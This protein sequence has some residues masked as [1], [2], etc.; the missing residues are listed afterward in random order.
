MED[1]VS[2]ILG[3]GLFIV[4]VILEGIVIGFGG[5]I[6]NVSD[7]DLDA[8][9]G[10]NDKKHHLLQMY[11][12]NR[13]RYLQIIQCATVIL[14][15]CN[16]FVQY[17]SWNHFLH[18]QLGYSGFICNLLIFIVV[19]FLFLILGIF[20]PWIVCERKAK[21]KAFSY[22]WAF[23]CI[24]CIL[25]PVLGIV[26]LISR[27]ISRLFGVDPTT[28]LDDVTEEEIISMVNEGHEHGVLLASEAA[29]IQNIFE[30]GDKNAKD[31]MIHR[32]NIIAMDGTWSL[33]DAVSFMNENHN[34]RYPVYQ[35]NLDDIIGI[36]HIK[37]A[38]EYMEK[39][40]ML[41]KEIKDIPGLIRQAE[42]VP[43][44]HGIN[45]LFTKM[46]S[47]KNHMV[48]VV[49][50]YGQTSGIISMEDILEEIVGNIQ[51]EHDDEEDTIEK[52][53]EDHFI[54]EGRTS[55]DEVAEILDIS[56][57]DEEV[58]TLNGFLISKI[59][60]IPSDHESFVVTAKGYEF[61]V[62]DVEN[63]MI[64]N[65]RVKKMTSGDTLESI[66]EK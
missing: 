55:L 5:G 36:F 1:G 33:K 66:Q 31:I 34:S 32:K 53:T 22:V 51:D 14:I 60:K 18:N 11:H 65:V 26:N 47:E 54:M 45:T 7:K 13:T 43:E 40:D 2:P 59:D 16:T 12:D 23:R 50:E 3:L 48:I 42:F 58:E 44:T 24:E 17:F 56:F 63:K 57:E 20:V 4:F 52:V 21:K 6:E 39:P 27:C 61:T 9:E 19:V 37:E 25:S 41:F 35:E 62:L 46:Q 30:F 29:M 28:E 38:L 15:T 64:Q 10:K 8:L 49:D